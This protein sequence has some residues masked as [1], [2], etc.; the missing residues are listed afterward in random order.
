MTRSDYVE[1]LKSKRV[2]DS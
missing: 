2:I 1:H